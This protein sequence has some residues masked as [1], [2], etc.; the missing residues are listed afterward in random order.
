MR[1]PFRVPFR[2]RF[3][4]GFRAL[5]NL[6]DPTG[7]RIFS[8]TP[9]ELELGA[10]DDVTVTG[11]R[12]ADGCSAEFDGDE[13]DVTVNSVTFVG[14]NELT[15]SVTVAGDAAPGPYALTVTNPDEQS[16]TKGA[17]LQV[18]VAENRILLENGTDYLL[19][20]SG[21]YVLQEA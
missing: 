8:L 13:G 16:H 1:A 5:W 18:L 14:E 7:P 15:L 4:A 2:T 3:R 17:A 12:F 19:T 21:D 9:S 10:T 20:E 11:L 6:E